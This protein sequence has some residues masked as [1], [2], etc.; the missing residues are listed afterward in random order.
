MRCGGRLF[1]TGLLPQA[2]VLLLRSSCLPHTLLPLLSC[3]ALLL[4]DPLLLETGLLASEAAPSIMQIPK[5]SQASQHDEE[6]PRGQPHCQACNIHPAT[7]CGERVP[8]I[9]DYG[10]CSTPIPFPKGMG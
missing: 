7:P 4:E 9:Q 5:G 8:G 2:L 1:I 3:I 6:D 10:L